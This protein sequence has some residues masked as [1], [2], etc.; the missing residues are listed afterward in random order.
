MLSANDLAAMRAVQETAMMDT[1][2]VLSYSDGATDDYGKP[3]LT[4]LPNAA[5][6]CGV[7]YLQ[8]NYARS[9]EAM[10]DVGLFATSI[11]I[12]LE[13]PLTNKDRIKVTHRF[14]EAL[15]AAVV[16]EIAGEIRR[17]PTCLTVEVRKV[18]DG[19]GI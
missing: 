7:R 15:D 14:G 9:G 8:R 17:G 2:V 19:S 5:I 11:R 6:A 1:C 13:T 3:Q 12:P 18:T 16:Y 10:D 4:H